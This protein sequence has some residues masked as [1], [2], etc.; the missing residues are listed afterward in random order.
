MELFDLPNQDASYLHSGGIP[1][2]EFDPAYGNMKRILAMSGFTHVNFFMNNYFTHAYP[3]Q[4]KFYCD[5]VDAKI[6]IPTHGNNPERLL[7]K[8]GR[9]QFLPELRK[10]YVLENDK[11]VEVS[12]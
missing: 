1:I 6:L 12:K 10:T 9:T 2:G 8:E 3:P 11:L 5:E 7:A 4:V